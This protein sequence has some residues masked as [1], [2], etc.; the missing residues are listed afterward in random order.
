MLFIQSNTQAL[1]LTDEGRVRLLDALAASGRRPLLRDARRRLFRSLVESA[2]AGGEVEAAAASLELS[3]AARGGARE[4]TAYAPGEL[5]CESDC[6]L[7][8]VFNDGEAG[9]TLAASV[10]YNLD[11]AEPLARLERFCREVQAALD[12]LRTDAPAPP[13]EVAPQPDLPLW[14]PRGGRA[15]QGLARFVS[16][17][18]PDFVRAA[19]ALRGGRELARASELLEQREVREFLRRVEELRREGFTPRRLLAEAGAL[20]TVSVERMLEAGLIERE[21]RVSCRKSGHALFDLPSPDSLAAVTISRA[22]CSLCAAPVADEVVEET[23]SPSRLAVALL[24]DGGWLANRVYRIVRSLGVPES[25]ISTGPPTPHGESYLAADVCGNT[26]IV[27]TRDG[28]LT[29]AFARRVAEIVEDADATHLIA[30]VTGAADDEGRM[31]LYEF[32]WRRAR[33]GRD[34]NTT[35]VEGLEG[36]RGQMARAF[37]TAVRRE[38]S[39]GLFPLDAALGFSASGFVLEWF[40]SQKSRAARERREDERAPAR[41]AAG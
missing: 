10:V 36:A 25:D 1:S 5:F 21:L 29:P 18:P 31:R 38:L 34:L 27:V 22:R 13:V 3:C 33:G 20:G 23:F 14:R 4:G 15:P 40:R 19:A 12:S 24:E 32:A 28:D 17:Q 37:E 30:V 39:R 7:A 6:V 8:L 9:G 11:T 26:F 16:A 35:V 2:V 41:L